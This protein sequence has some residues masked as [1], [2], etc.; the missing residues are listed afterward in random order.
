MAFKAVIFDLDG[1][2][3]DTAKY[4][5]IAWQKI[6]SELGISFSKADNEHLKGVSRV[7]SLELILSWHNKSLSPSEFE[8]ALKRKN[9]IYLEYIYTLQPTEIMSGVVPFLE[10]L[11]KLGIPIAVGSAS[12]NAPLILDKLGL[13]PYFKSIVDGNSVTKAKPDPEVFLVA[14][15]KLETAPEDCLVFEDAQAG[16]DAAVAG[17]MTAVAIDPEHQLKN[18]HAHLV[19]FEGVSYHSLT[20]LLSA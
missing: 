13:T 14:A 18:H 10:E 6:A 7:K 2:L 8:A 9:E 15:Q 3:V 16:I 4:H 20:Q 1:V 11:K 19:G 5:F 12:K 17:K